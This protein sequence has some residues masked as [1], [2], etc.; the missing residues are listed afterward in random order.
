MIFNSI[1]ILCNLFRDRTP[2]QSRDIFDLLEALESWTSIASSTVQSRDYAPL[3]H[4]L[5]AL[6]AQI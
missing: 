2:N 5:P 3:A 4:N 1:I 6:L